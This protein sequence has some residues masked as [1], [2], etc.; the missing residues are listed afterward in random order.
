MVFESR[1]L[2]ALLALSTV[3]C[4]VPR[5]SEHYS[6]ERFEKTVPLTPKG[7]F[8]LQNVNGDLRV[9]AWDKNEVEIVAKKSGRVSEIAI[10]V[11]ERPDEVDVQTRFPHHTFVLFRRNTKVDYSIRVPAL[12][13]LDLD[14]VNGIV[15]ID[16]PAGRTRVNTVNAV[17]NVRRA[18]GEVRAQSVNGAVTVACAHVVPDGTYEFET[19]NGKVHLTLPANVSG[20]FRGSTVNGWIETDFPLE[21]SGKFLMHD[22]SGHIGEGGPSFRLSAVNG[23]L[24]IK[25]APAET[26]AR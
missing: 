4:V 13:R 14:T 16:D 18:R 17:I 26:A 20:E 9:E 11:T 22:L 2:A 1:S 25:K 23:M 10:E 15:D 12:A 8:R 3:A 5:E 24:A 21:V 19:T 6:T 7:T